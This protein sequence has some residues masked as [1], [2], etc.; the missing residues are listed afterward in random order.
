LGKNKEIG[1]KGESIA[2]EYLIK[3]GYRILKT[4][5]RR[6]RFE[7]DIIGSKEDVL[8]FFEVKTRKNEVFGLPEDAI[9]DKKISRILDCANEYILETQWLKRIRFDIISITLSPRIRINHIRDAFF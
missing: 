7:I 4:N 3:T 1:N 8:V 6:G 9:D 2:V 5:Y